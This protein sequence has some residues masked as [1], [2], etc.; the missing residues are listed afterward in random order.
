MEKEVNPHFEDFLFDWDQKFQF[1]VGGYGSSKSYHIAL[2]LI[3]KL[4]DEKRTALVIRE[5][6]DTHRD[7]TFSLFEQ[8]VNDLGLDHVIQC[9]TSPLMLK[10]HNGSR[11]IFKGLD[12]PTKLKSINNISIIW[13]EECSEVKYE[14]FKEL[15]GRL[16]HPTLQLHMILSTN[17]V[18]QD[19]WTYRHF[20]KDD[21]NNRFILDDERLYKERTIAINDTYYHHSTAEDNLFLPV[22][23]IK[24]L[25]ELKEYDPDLYRIARKGHFGINGIRVL[26]QFEVQ[27][28]EDVML[29]IS[30]INRPLLRAGMDFGFV[31][32]YNAVVRLAVDHEKKYLYIYWEYYDRGKTDDVTVEDLKEFIETKELIKADNEQKTI[33]YFRKMGYNMVAAHKFQG[34]RLQYTK[35]IKRFKKIICSDSCKNTI[36]E[37]QPLTYKTDK[38]GN[39]IEDEFQID[40]HTFSAI[41]YALD[42]YEVTDL[43]EKPKER[44]RPNRERRS[45]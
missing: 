38:R 45:R 37:L 40:P 44:T 1:L 41:W 43:K 21:Q 32:S 20:F 17:P 24:Q 14:G 29:A 16:R 25:D 4:L 7:S 12:K 6:Y 22:S 18:G 19:N 8:I 27:P 10:F 34:S 3:L 30:N 15:L 42:D 5:V 2:K 26:P 23:Y 9:R 35:K 39:I 11:I 33:A 13:I 28:H 36:Y 31:D